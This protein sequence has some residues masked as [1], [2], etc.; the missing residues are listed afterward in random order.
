MLFQ[1]RPARGR[2][3]SSFADYIRSAVSRSYQRSYGPARPQLVGAPFGLLDRALLNGHPAGLSPRRAADRLGTAVWDS[4]REQVALLDGNGVVMSVN[5]AWR[6]FG[7]DH[8]GQPAGGLGSNY[9][10]VCARA[11]NAG[12]PGAARAADIVRTAVAGRDP[13]ARLSYHGGADNDRVFS[14]EAIPLPGRHSGA[15]VIHTDITSR[16]Q[17]ALVALL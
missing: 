8:G 6:Q 16:R 1:D 9:L 7:L 2:G 11:A 17:L 5:R 13:F 12:E 10:A 15:L 4:A 14:L 3:G